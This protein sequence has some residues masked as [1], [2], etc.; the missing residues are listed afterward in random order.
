MFIV[1]AENFYKNASETIN[2]I[3]N[4]K[5]PVLQTAHITKCSDHIFNIYI[6]TLIYNSRSRQPSMEPVPEPPK[7]ERPDFNFGLRPRLIQAG[8]DFKLLCI[9]QSTPTPKVRWV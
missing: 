8:T 9:V 5:I 7:E 2:L 1:C 3:I 6:V 4:F